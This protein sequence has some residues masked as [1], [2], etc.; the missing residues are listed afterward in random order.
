[1]P[2]LSLV[3]QYLFCAWVFYHAASA[4][5]RLS[6]N[7]TGLHKAFTI[8]SVSSDCTDWEGFVLS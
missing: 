4:T 5:Y 2:R 8:V 7:A 6:S 3:I 1:M